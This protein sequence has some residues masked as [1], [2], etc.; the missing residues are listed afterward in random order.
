MIHAFAI[1]NLDDEIVVN[2]VRDS[3]SLCKVDF[4]E[5][6][7]DEDEMDWLALERMGFECVPVTINTLQK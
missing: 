4:V 2:S 3:E 5:D 6:C 1:K 7:W